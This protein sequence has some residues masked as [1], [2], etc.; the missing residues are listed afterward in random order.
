MNRIGSRSVRNATALISS[1][2]SEVVARG[3]RSAMVVGL[4]NPQEKERVNSSSRGS[5]R[6]VW[7]K[8]ARKIR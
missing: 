7:T 3:S 6:P 2:L 8:N 4:S 1:A 5:G